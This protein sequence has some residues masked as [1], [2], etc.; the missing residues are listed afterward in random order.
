[1]YKGFLNKEVRK[2]GKKGKNDNNMR[3]NKRQMN[4]ETLKKGNTM[5]PFNKQANG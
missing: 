5:V 2:K 1:M 3:K 4:K